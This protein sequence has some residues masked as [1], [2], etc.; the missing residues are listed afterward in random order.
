MLQRLD[1]RGVRGDLGVL[2]PRP[3]IAGDE[4]TQAVREILRDVEA[5]GDAALIEL[6]ARFDGIE[7]PVIAVDRSEIHAALGR[8]DSEVREALEVAATRV[9]AFHE[10]QRHEPTTFEAG[11]TIA[12]FDRPVARAGCYV[13]GGRAAYPSTVLMTALPAR[14]AGVARDRRVRPGGPGHWPD[15]RRHVGRLCDRGRR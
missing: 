13:P 10:T 8:I 15:Q 14:V 6:T 5:R 9:R 12:S 11:G 3:S 1:V 2:L 4:P 7:H